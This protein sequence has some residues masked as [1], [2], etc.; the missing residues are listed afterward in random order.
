MK[1]NATNVDTA[2]CGCGLSF[3]KLKTQAHCGNPDGCCMH[4]IASDK[5]TDETGAH[6]IIQNSTYLGTNKLV[7]IR[8]S[9]GGFMTVWEPREL[10]AIDDKAVP[11]ELERNVD[12][13]DPDSGGLFAHD[14]H[15]PKLGSVI[16]KRTTVLDCL[17]SNC[18]GLL[19]LGQSYALMWQTQA[20]W[21]GKTQP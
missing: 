18:N 2:V 13:I 5:Y 17:A 16:K 7:S 10:P 11:E 12:G 19:M 14:V 4:V 15:L 21:A 6:R 20:Y 8:R 3:I 9:N 1:R